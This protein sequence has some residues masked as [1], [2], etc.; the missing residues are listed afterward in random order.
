MSIR[1]CV[2]CGGPVRVASTRRSESAV[3][4]VATNYY[5]C[6][7][8]GPTDARAPEIHPETAESDRGLRTPVAQASSSRPVAR[9][10][11]DEQ[12]GHP[13]IGANRVEEYGHRAPSSLIGNVQPRAAREG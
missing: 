3:V 7:T 10:G 6:E 12:S 1:V 5:R 11:E 8:C 2:Q 9:P 13:R 4:G